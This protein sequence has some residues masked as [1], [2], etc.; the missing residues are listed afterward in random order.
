MER[1]DL[2]PEEVAR[3]DGTI[4]RS[5]VIEQPAQ[6]RRRLWWAYPDSLRSHVG[7]DADS[8]AVGVVFLAMQI[9]RPVRIHGQVSPSLL[10][11]LEEFQAAWTAME[12]SLTPVEITADEEVEVV[13]PAGR[14]GGL[15]AFSGGVDCS[16]TAYRHV[17][18]AGVRW[19][20]KIAAG[21]MVHGFD[22]PL[23]DSQ[24]FAA[25]AARSRRTLDSLGLP[26]LTV[27]CN[28]KE[29]VADFPHS[30]G[31]AI[32]SCLALFANGFSYGLIG[33]TFTYAESR[34]IAEGVNPLTDPL[35]SSDSFAVIP[36]GAAF[37]R[38]DKIRLLGNWE[39][40][41]TNLRVCWAG[42]QKDRNCCNCEKC[43]RNILTFRALGL[44]LPECFERDVP[45]LRLASVKM[46]EGI[47]PFI[48]YGE[49]RELS[50]AN[51]TFGNWAKVLSWRLAEM[52]FRNR[53][54]RI[55]RRTR[56][57]WYIACRARARLGRSRGA[58]L[59]ASARPLPVNDGR[60]AS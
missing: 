41:R 40:F 15:V 14:T 11:N 49:L 6:A 36:D 60:S 51:G 42:P 33:Q 19:P 57:L 47:R 55:W 4:V 9:G 16:F 52:R 17:R 27:A 25:A 43:I 38:A 8:L 29:V 23:S 5:L 53:W 59:I 31:A 35:L 13:R 1:L 32:A 24:A 45:D 58:G 46:G 20:R 12:R 26:L 10:R 34:H 54:P 50:Q 28:Y 7:G 22:I 39:E 2:W 56:W 21:V 18:A 30:H 3:G 48:R 44:G 37:E